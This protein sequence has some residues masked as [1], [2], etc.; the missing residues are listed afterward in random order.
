VSV[1]NQIKGIKTR[2]PD[3]HTLNQLEEVPVFVYGTLKKGFSN[4]GCMRDSKFLGDARTLDKLTMRNSGFP[5]LLKEGT[6]SAH[7]IFGELYAVKPEVVKDYLDPLEG[8]NNIYTRE[9]LMVAMLQQDTKAPLSG[10]HPIKSAWVYI[11]NNDYW[12]DRTLSLCPTQMK[13]NKLSYVY[14]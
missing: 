5:V 2:T 1:M 6:S 13:Y 9:K 4:H 12:A 14:S 3:W 10:A 11:G 8:N 7:H